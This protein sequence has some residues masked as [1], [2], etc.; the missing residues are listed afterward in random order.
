M[1]LQ[2]PLFWHQGLFLQP[3]HFQLADLYHE[4]LL[5]PLKKY[6]EPY[7]WGVGDMEIQKTALGN[8][9][10]DL[11]KSELLFPD[12][13]Y[14]VF[15][16]NSVIEARSFEEEWVEGGKPF[17]VFV[18]LKKWSET[19]E[20]VS[21]LPAL[22]N[23]SQV[24]T[25]FVTTADPEEV[26]D[27]HHVGP[28]AQVKRLYHALKIFWESEKDQLGDYL[29]LPVGQLVR[30]G[31]EVALAEDFVPPSLSISS[32]EPLSKTV[33]EIRDEIA[34]RS[35]QLEEYKIQ[36]GIHTAEFGAR[37]M[38]YLLALRSLNRYVPILY[39]FTEAPRVPPWIVYGIIR[40]LL[41]ELSSFSE[42]F[43]VM[44]EIRDEEDR[45]PP[46]DHERLWDCFS[47]AQIMVVRLLDEIT[48]G[49]EYILRLLYDGTYY[50]A[51]LPPAIFEGQNRFY[52]V[53]KTEEDPKVV[54]QSLE[55][56][57][58]LSSREHL[59]ILIARALPGIGLDHLPVPPQEL[60][61]RADCVY[62]QID[63]H[64]DQWASVQKGKN[65]GLYW[66]SA[67]EDLGA[68]LMVVGRS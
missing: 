16:G 42:R 55:S 37:D 21:V 38:V 64:S 18:G 39:H 24:T 33:K 44:G 62:F 51:D 61:R 29:T 59:P 30:K 15:P 22:D 67:P 23:I 20:N 41:G 34:A 54:I 4:A 43:T 32:S 52:L 11:L 19:D 25:R 28:S 49:P 27:L 17:T 48:A 66:D 53:L 58:K 56:V 68:E 63:H 13:T 10:F 57:A 2:R 1:D 45:L 7:F 6:V 60:P 14:A 50:A 36:K 5:T 40:Q 35:H 9:T 47:S 46:Y 31:E 3:Q 12:G 26:R 8:R 65:V